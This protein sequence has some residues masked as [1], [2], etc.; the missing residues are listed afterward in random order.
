MGAEQQA[1]ERIQA[2]GVGRNLPRLDVRGAKQWQMVDAGNGTYSSPGDDQCVAEI[3]LADACGLKA[4]ALG[5]RIVV[6][7][8]DTNFSLAGFDPTMTL[9]QVN[10]CCKSP[11]SNTDGEAMAASALAMFGDVVRKGAEIGVY[12]AARRQRDIYAVEVCKFVRDVEKTGM[13]HERAGSRVAF[14]IDDKIASSELVDFLGRTNDGEADT[15]KYRNKGIAVERLGCVGAVGAGDDRKVKG[16]RAALPGP[17]IVGRPDDAQLPDMLGKLWP[18]LRRENIDGQAL[19]WFVATI[20]ARP[21]GYARTGKLRII[22][23][24][25]KRFM[26]RGLN[27]GGPDRT[28][29]KERLRWLLGLLIELERCWIGA[30][31]FR[32]RVYGNS[33]FR[34]MM[35]Q[36]GDDFGKETGLTQ[37]IVEHSCHRISP[38]HLQ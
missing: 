29:P 15:A 30:P 22:Q 21:I 5:Q 20:R 27:E 4:F 28:L 31:E 23:A 19:A 12:I 32:E 13:N 8:N 34:C 11:S 7:C 26:W 35:T 18:Q 10:E 24:D 16:L 17:D 38:F 1:V 37:E 36:N 3:P 9:Q 6:G 25:E 14:H 33:A 2:F